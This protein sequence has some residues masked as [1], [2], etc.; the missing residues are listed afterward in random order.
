[1]QQQLQQ[2]IP[3]VQPQQARAAAE[4][5]EGRSAHGGSAQVHSHLQ[6]PYV[7]DKFSSSSQQPVRRARPH[8]V[9]SQGEYQGTTPF[10]PFP[11]Q[12]TPD[13]N[14]PAEPE[15]EKNNMEIAKGKD[16]TT[17]LTGKYGHFQNRGGWEATAGWGGTE[18]DTKIGITAPSMVD[19]DLAHV[20]PM[21]EPQTINEVAEIGT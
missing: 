7:S 13:T 8:Q 16:H 3:L 9:L 15:T 11:E 2:Q 14:L 5:Q 4:V 10:V 12:E 19:Q 6:T 17:K 21:L 1:M 18:Y 20:Q